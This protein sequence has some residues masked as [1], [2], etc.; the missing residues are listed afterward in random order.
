[1][2]IDLFI[3]SIP[4]SRFYAWFSLHR[5]LLG[6]GASGDFRVFRASISTDVSSCAPS[7]TLAFPAIPQ[8][9]TDGAA[10]SQLRKM[11]QLPQMHQNPGLR[12]NLPYE[13][14]RMRRLTGSREIVPT[15]F[16]SSSAIA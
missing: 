7:Q 16:F 15:P 1:M 12:A 6:S 5:R 4:P 14:R 11:T 13:P 9:T 3:G 10:V 2:T 8:A